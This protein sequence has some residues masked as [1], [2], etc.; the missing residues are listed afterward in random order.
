MATGKNLRILAHNIHDTA[1]LTATS[2]ALPISNTQRSERPLVWRSTTIAEQV[3]EAAL[4]TGAYIDCIALVRHNLGAN[5]LRRI[6]L[7]HHDT[8][9]YDSGFV[10]TALLIPAG[11]WR[12]GIDP[13]G[14]TYNDQLPGSVPMT[15]HWLAQ[16]HLIT[17]Y[18]I[19]VTGTPADG[20][21][22]IGRIFV[23][24]TWSP[25]DNFSWSPQ[26]EWAESGEHIRTEGGSLRTIGAADLYRRVQIQL[27]WLND[28]DRTQ[29]ITLLAKAG[30][31][32]DML[33]SLY[34]DSESMMLELEGVMVCRR[35]GSLNTTHNLHRNWQAPLTFIEV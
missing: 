14:A 7:L 29:M 28:A 10:P 20:Y 35:D 34:P 25:R 13:W 21:I 18:R 15:V 22:E 32:A 4:P 23:G 33:I 12:A 1:S 16:A 30:I 8:V 5:G 27:D 6:E 19:T 9:V 2:E 11:I 3:I 31:G 17:G 26:V 24:M